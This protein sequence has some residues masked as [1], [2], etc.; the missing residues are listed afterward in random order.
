MTLLVRNAVLNGYLD[1]VRSLDAEPLP[2][3]RS[4]G[5][6]IADVA[7]PNQWVAVDAVA[8]LLELSAEVTDTE[9][10]GLRLAQG[11]RLSN[12]GPISLAAREEPDVRSVLRLISRYDYL[13]SEAFHIR[14]TE[15]DGLATIKFGLDMD[16]SVQH[17][18]L[19]ELAVGAVLQILKLLVGRNLLQP[20]AVSLMYDPPR[21]L[22]AHQQVLG[23]G[24]RFDGEFNGFV[25]YSTDLD[26]PNIWSDPSL[27]PFAKQY[28]AEIVGPRPEDDLDRIQDLIET[29]LPTGRCS[30]HQ[31][32]KTLGV[33]RVTVHRRLARTNTS[34][35]EMLNTTRRK[36]AVRHVEQQRRSLTE[37]AELLGFS[38]PSAFS[39]WFRS[40]FGSSPS[41]WR[42]LHRAGS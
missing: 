24:I 25:L 34:F 11:R 4:V 10:F 31:I 20:V 23:G 41:A 22:S 6:Q 35:S 12:V 33:N 2:L 36:L 27:R 39:R 30:L 26:A 3:L 7:L 1:L 42:T 40:E 9:G 38:E 16:E 17:R 21:D 29:M 8:R 13:H 15:A 19:A 14:V 37:I 5:L 18:Q 32:A 28:L